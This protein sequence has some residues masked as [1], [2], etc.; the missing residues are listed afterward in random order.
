MKKKIL[1]A[2]FFA[3]LILAAPTKNL[4]ATA[5]GEN[6][7]KVMALNY[8]KID[9]ME[10]SLSVTPADF[11]A[12]MKYLK[13]NGYNI[14]DIADLY[15]ALAGEKTLP[16]NPVLITFDD[17][18]ADNYT[19][20]YPILKKYGF[21]ATIFVITDFVDV[22]ANYLKWEQLKEMSQNGITIESHTATHNSLT[23][24]T[25]EQLKKELIDSKQ[26]IE[27]ELGTTVDFIAYPTG[28]Y[29]LHIAQLVK[30]AGYKGA[31]TIK[32]GNIDANSNIYALERVPVF[33]TEDTM[34][35]FIERLDYTPLFAS[36]GWIK[37]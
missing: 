1:A 32:Y 6:G 25:D 27:A 30:D 28:A 22:R 2:I 7:V 37:N 17:G 16:K 24:L 3:A 11:D 35:S 10:I 14:I 13:D 31:F 20:A 19:A 34:K 8:H 12:Q 36:H 9:D 21:K 5:D 23:D 15:A 4:F 33:H 29:N 18:Y 26:K